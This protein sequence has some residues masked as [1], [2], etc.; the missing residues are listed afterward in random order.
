MDLNHHVL[1]YES[2]ELPLLYFAQE[3]TKNWVNNET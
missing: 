3:I 1:G 2:N